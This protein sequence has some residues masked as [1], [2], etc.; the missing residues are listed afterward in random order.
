MKAVIKPSK[1]TGIAAAPPSKSMAHRMLICAGLSE[2]ES[3]VKGIAP[4]QDVLATLD[5]L[6]ALGAEYKYENETVVIR[7]ADLQNVKDGTVL[8]CR[9]CGS[10]LRFFIPIALLTGKEIIFTGSETLMKRPLG[11]YEDMC[12]EHGFVF[13]REKRKAAGSAGQNEK[14]EEIA[15]CI[16]IQ[17]RLRSGE[18]RIPGNISS[19]FISGLLFALPKSGGSS[20]IAII[21]P[22]ESRPYIDMTVQALKEFGV[23]AVWKDENTLFINAGQKYISKSTAV[24]GDYSNAAFLEA[25]NL[26]GGDVKVGGLKDDSLQGDKIYKALFD[27]I[28]SGTPNID[29]SDCP[30]LGP[31]LMAAAALK[32][33][34]FFTGTKRLKIKESDRG[35]A[36]KQE[37]EKFGIR[38]EVEED[39]ITVHKGALRSPMAELD[40]HN[41]HRIVMALSVL[42]SVTGGVID[43]AQAV[44]KSFPDFFDK[45][46]K[47]GI[48][49][50]LK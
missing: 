38:A 35:E 10:T 20:A 28:K 21:P 27:Q 8:N 44:N 5:C 1:A 26:A 6:E 17:G 12:A 40:G 36:M 47:L 37:L 22:V 30:D 46:K 4:S 29:I 7:G 14:A 11:V 42:A 45:I 43:G 39:S 34:A 16:R 2:G 41:D 24:E 48:D 3:T 19:Q 13:K 25:F 49:A 33:G 9:E 32:D 31:V 15:D 18:Y 23:E 50:E